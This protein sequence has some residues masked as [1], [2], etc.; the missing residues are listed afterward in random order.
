[1]RGHSLWIHVAILNFKLK[2]MSHPYNKL[3]V[4]GLVSGFWTCASMQG[5]TK[6]RVWLA[7]YINSIINSPIRSLLMMKGP[8]IKRGSGK[9]LCS[10]VFCMTGPLAAMH[11]HKS[12]WQHGMGRSPSLHK[13]FVV[14]DSKQQCNKTPTRMITKPLTSSRPTVSD[15]QVLQ[16]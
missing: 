8:C 10:T 1:M 15:D 2:K 11:S 5:R 4:W 3:Y 7:A 14:S 12:I 16:L 9:D 13:C 6:R